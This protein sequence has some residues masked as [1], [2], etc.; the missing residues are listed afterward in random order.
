M[1]FVFLI[2][3]LVAFLALSEANAQ[4]DQGWVVNTIVYNGDTIPYIRFREVVIMPPKVFS[5]KREAMRYRK[6][7]RKVKK[8]LP[9]A[10][11][12]KKK[13]VEIELAVAKMDS[14][15]ERKKF[16]NQKDKELKAEFEKDLTD[17]TISEGLILIKLIDRETGDTSF[18]LIKELKGSM[19][20]FMW[21]SVARLFG[22]NLK[23]EYDPNG[24]DKLIEEIVLRIENGQL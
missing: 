18:E 21:Q 4:T 9:Y 20:A 13:L 1:R 5:S 11:I 8:A 24:E 2:S 19:N 6:L 10:K 17:F 22:S 16:I 7:A 15:K 23:M 3:L 14:E 12:A